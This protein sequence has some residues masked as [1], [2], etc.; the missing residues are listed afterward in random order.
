MA[1]KIEYQKLRTAEVEQRSVKP[2]ADL[3]PVSAKGT[4][5]E[6]E[7]VSDK[8]TLLKTLMSEMVPSLQRTGEMIEKD[9]T[10]QAQ[11]QAA[12]DYTKGGEYKNTTGWRAYED[13]YF[14]MKGEADANK[15]KAELHDYTLKN[16]QTTPEEF[17]AG[18]RKIVA[19]YSGELDVP[20]Y[21]SSFGHLAIQAEAAANAQYKDLLH[22]DTVKK[23]QEDAAFNFRGWLE[24][25]RT[26]VRNG[27]MS[28]D[29]MDAR[30]REKVDEYIQLG[31]P[32]GQRA[33]DVIK[34]LLEAQG[35]YMGNT[36]DH[37]SVGWTKVLG[38]DGIAV[39]QSAL[40]PLVEKVQLEALSVQQRK[41]EIKEYGR[42]MATHQ[43]SR[44]I[45]GFLVDY[46]DT[47]NP[48]SLQQAEDMIAKHSNP[49]TPDVLMD[50]EEQAKFGALVKAVKTG[51]YR[52]VSDPETF[53]K[54]MKKVERGSITAWDI[55]SAARLLS[56]EDRTTLAYHLAADRE[57]DGNKMMQVNLHDI[58]QT[59]TFFRSQFQQV[60][61][62]G[63]PKD[64]M[65]SQK[66]AEFQRQMQDFRT[67]FWR[68]K[69]Y[70][71]IDSET[72]TKKS[73]EVFNTI[74]KKY[75]GAASPAKYI[76]D[77]RLP[78]F[79]NQAQPV[80]PA[81]GGGKSGS[82]SGTVKSGL[83]TPQIDPETQRL[84]NQLDSFKA[85]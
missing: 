78:D 25:Y 35:A 3:K 16:W 58:Y 43:A 76:E 13:A 1:Q 15:L 36:G 60:D 80:A 65:W 17:E 69:G 18:K 56:K 72:Y 34:T 4:Q 51:S 24:E 83:S 28:Q 54:L 84:M 61:I 45:L 37:E 63:I 77:P 79:K 22:S 73:T 47:G 52:A 20:A 81:A 32:L 85:K 55:D 82:K 40:A 11:A 68:T 44:Q 29:E 48:E 46:G 9:Y 71:P 27:A 2:V 10:K 19:S 42:K 41:L 33:P 50:V 53:D 23:W 38:K 6:V 62:N 75:D 7:G 59:D 39:Q 8:T 5:Y 49:N 57:K 21:A 26:A 12:A 14:K 30:I 70:T 67:N 66:T 64:P 74:Q 31:K